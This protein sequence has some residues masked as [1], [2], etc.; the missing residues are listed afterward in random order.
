MRREDSGRN[1]TSDVDVMAKT[2]ANYVPWVDVSEIRPL[3]ARRGRRHQPGG[4]QHPVGAG[5]ERGLAQILGGCINT[6]FHPRP[7]ADAFYAGT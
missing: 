7:G 3:H 2:I 6:M 4:V 1:S 5:A